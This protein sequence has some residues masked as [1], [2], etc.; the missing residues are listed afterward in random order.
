[1]PPNQHRPIA[2]YFGHGHRPLKPAKTY[3]FYSSFRAKM[4]ARQTSSA[5][6]TVQLLL[7]VFFL[8]TGSKFLIGR[9]KKT[10]NIGENGRYLG[11][12]YTK[13]DH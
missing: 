10:G 9:V 4:E 7:P 5:F 2:F 6:G 11:A 12:F 1:M 3:Q 13:V 8:E